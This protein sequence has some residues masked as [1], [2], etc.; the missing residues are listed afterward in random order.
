M[1]Q[2]VCIAIAESGRGRGREVREVGIFENRPDVLRK[3]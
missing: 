2:V 3:W 1:C